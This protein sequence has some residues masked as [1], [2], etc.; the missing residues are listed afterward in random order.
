[1]TLPLAAQSEL[2]EVLTFEMDRETPFKADEL[3]W[4]HRLETADRQK[5]RLSVRLML[6]PKVNLAPLLAAFDWVGIHPSRI[7]IAGGPDAG[8]CLPLA[9]AGGQ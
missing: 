8:S 2:R 1:M 6:I 3:Y 4:N 7:E 9:N 5:G